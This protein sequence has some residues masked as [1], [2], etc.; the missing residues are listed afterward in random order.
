MKISNKFK[1]VVKNDTAFL[2]KSNMRGDVL[3][4]GEGIG[5]DILLAIHAHNSSLEDLLEALKKT[6]CDVPAEIIENDVKEFVSDLI[7]EGIVEDKI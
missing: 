5:N 6:Y 4:H 7:S 3:Y 2:L 1:V